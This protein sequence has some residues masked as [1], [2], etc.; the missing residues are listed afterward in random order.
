MIITSFVYRRPVFRSPRRD[1]RGRGRGGGVCAEGGGDRWVFDRGGGPLGVVAGDDLALFRS[2]SIVADLNSSDRERRSNAERRADG[3][4]APGPR[5]AFD[6]TFVND[7][8]GDR[9]PTNAPPARWVRPVFA[10]SRSYT[11]FG[12]AV[13]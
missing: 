11:F 12:L 7:D 5:A 3:L 8:A 6:R 13:R 4:L 9:F 1:E 2:G 10:P